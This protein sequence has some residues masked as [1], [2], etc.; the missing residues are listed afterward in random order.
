MP[1]VFEVATDVES[2]QPSAVSS[3]K[4]LRD[5]QLVIIRNGVE[6]NAAGQMVK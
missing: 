3:Q 4:V 1:F 2:I 6:Y 5:G